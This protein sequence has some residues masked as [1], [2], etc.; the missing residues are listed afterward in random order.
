MEEWGRG[1]VMESGEMDI[2]LSGID[3][4]RDNR[5]VAV[6][7]ANALCIKPSV[8]HDGM[9]MVRHFFGNP[10]FFKIKIVK[11]YR[12]DIDE[13]GPRLFTYQYVK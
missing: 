6:C 11:I 9:R 3:S 5:F 2:F 13:K 10:F 8:P 7:R 1:G 12:Q 4:S